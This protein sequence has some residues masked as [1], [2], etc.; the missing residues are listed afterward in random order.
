MKMNTVLKSHEHFC[1]S[2]MNVCK[3]DQLFFQKDISE[4]FSNDS[5]PVILKECKGQ[6]NSQDQESREV[7]KQSFSSVQMTRITSTRP[8]ALTLRTPAGRF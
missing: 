3:Y 1:S 8:S 4:M 5:G 6:G 2:S 7:V